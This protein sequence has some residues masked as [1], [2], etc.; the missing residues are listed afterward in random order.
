M[1][2]AF[3]ILFI[4]LICGISLLCGYVLGH[5]EAVKEH[6]M[7]QDNIQSLISQL[8][9]TMNEFSQKLNRNKND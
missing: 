6:K 2:I 5:N 4:I 7:W 9:S 1:D 3:S 8:N